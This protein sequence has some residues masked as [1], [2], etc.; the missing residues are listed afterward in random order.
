MVLISVNIYSTHC[1]YQAPCWVVWHSIHVAILR[2]FEN[3]E[4]IRSQKHGLLR[5]YSNPSPEWV[6]KEYHQGNGPS[7]RAPLGIC[8]KSPPLLLPPIPKWG[9][10]IFLFN[11]PIHRAYSLLGTDYSLLLDF[12]QL[13][14]L[15]MLVNVPEATVGIRA[16]SS[17]QEKK[18][19]TQ[20]HRSY[21]MSKS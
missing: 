13:P 8:P 17:R 14:L 4:T 10:I 12:F 19:K 6:G 11:W 21:Q 3:K 7:C 9:S 15:G 16:L 20:T 18:D 1:V 2:D 5:R